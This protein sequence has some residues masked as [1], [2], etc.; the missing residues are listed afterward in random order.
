MRLDIFQNFKLK[1]MLFD[2]D[3]FQFRR[4][5]RGAGS[6]SLTLNDLTEKENLMEDTIIIA[7]DEAWLIENVH[8][9]KNVRGEITLEVSGRHINAI[10]ERRVVE[11]FT[12]NV[13]DTVEIQLYKLI[14]DNFISP[15]IAARQMDNF[16]LAPAKGIT[17][18]ATTTYTLEKMSVLEILNKVCGYSGLGYRL[19]FYPEKQQFV[20]EILQGRNLSNQVFFSE[21]YGNVSEAEVYRESENYKNAG[22][23][24]GVWSGTA[25]GFDRREIILG[26]DEALSDYGRLVS[27]DGMVLDTE[28]FIYLEDWDLGDTVSYLDKTLGFFVENPILEIQETYEKEATMEVTF[29]ERIPTIF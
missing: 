20:F 18:K 5:F 7:R 8:G 4:M 23:N 19:C 26:D 10:L 25:T 28:Q 13:T 9:Y 22:L 17:K 29:G 6:F 27:V 1:T 16:Y 2:Y 21:E 3:S 11:A 15:A 24:N 14:D 12:I